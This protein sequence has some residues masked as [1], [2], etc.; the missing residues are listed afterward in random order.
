[1]EYVSKSIGVDELPFNGLFTLQQDNVLVMAER[2]DWVRDPETGQR[3]YISDMWVSSQ[4]VKCPVCSNKDY[5]GFVTFQGSEKFVFACK[6]CKKFIWAR[7]S[8]E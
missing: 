8:N 6:G 3:L 4:E 2:P 7:V 1:V 5:H